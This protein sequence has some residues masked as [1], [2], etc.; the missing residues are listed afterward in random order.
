MGFWIVLRGIYLRTV[1]QGLHDLQLVEHLDQ[2]CESIEH[3]KIE[4]QIVENSHKEIEYLNQKHEEL[5]ESHKGT[6]TE[7]QEKKDNCE[8]NKQSD[9]AAIIFLKGMNELREIEIQKNL[10]D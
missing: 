7:I 4:D 9:L 6:C 1:H 3:L 10:I 2:V 5:Q 8:F